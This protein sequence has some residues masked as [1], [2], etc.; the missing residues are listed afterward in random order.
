M[1]HKGMRRIFLV[2][3]IFGILFWPQVGDTETVI[4]SDD[5]VTITEQQVVANDFYAAAKKV[6]QAGVVGEDMYAF[7][8]VV[9]VGGEV[10]DDLNIVAGRV[11]ISGPIGD[12]VFVVAG[13]TIISGTVAGDVFAISDKVRILPQASVQG[14]VYAFGMFGG[15]LEVNGPVNGSIKGRVERVLIDTKVGGEVDVLARDGVTLAAAAN[16]AGDLRYVS[17]QPL[18]RAP[19]AVVVGEIVAQSPNTRDA[20][21]WAESVIPGLIM[22]FASL[23]LYLLTRGFVLE[24]VSETLTRPTRSAL[25]GLLTLVLGPTV[26]VVLSVSVLGLVVGIGLL[27]LI[28][29][30]AALAYAVAPMVVGVLLWRCVRKQAELNPLIILAGA[31]TLQMIWYLPLIIGPVLIFSCWVI[32]VGALTSLIGKI[33]THR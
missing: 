10:R 33:F 18:I 6:S 21:T 19:D 1:K 31:V 11:D 3:L 8:G 24:V 13:E 29:F 7:G 23:V 2:S 12:D 27:G 16:I 9:T 28:I 25:T 30:V 4:R 32:V 15:T 17:A 14:D 20:K 26:A 5:L 22:L